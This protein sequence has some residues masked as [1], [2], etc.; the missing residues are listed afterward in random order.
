LGQILG[1]HPP[2]GVGVAAPS[3]G[4]EAGDVGEDSVEAA[5]VM[6]YPFV[7]LAAQRPA[8]HV[9]NAGSAQPARSA[10]EAALRYLTGDELAAISHAGGER[11]SLAA[12]ACA[13]IDDPHARSR[14]G[15]KGGNLRAFVLHL[16]ETLLEGR[17]VAERRAVVQTQ[18]NRRQRS[19]LCG[20]TLYGERAARLFA[21]SLQQVD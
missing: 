21:V 10:I 7:A 19:G 6:L 4:A 5:F 3:A 12:R 17:E 11:Q 18:A 15:E 13:E 16:D 14:I 8:L 2:F 9:R 20:H 1:A